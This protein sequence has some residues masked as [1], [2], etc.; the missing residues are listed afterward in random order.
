MLGKWIAQQLYVYWRVSKSKLWNILLCVI[1]HCVQFAW[2]SYRVRWSVGGGGAAWTKKKK[3]AITVMYA[4]HSLQE[5][6]PLSF[7]FFLFFPLSLLHATI[8]ESGLFFTL[9]MCV[10]SQYIVGHRNCNSIKMKPMHQEN[11]C[12]RIVQIRV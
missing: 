6:R 10:S 4:L 8:A 5:P 1:I 2:L 12:K 3:V 9:R 11:T 7:V